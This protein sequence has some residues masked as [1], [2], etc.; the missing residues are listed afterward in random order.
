[1]DKPVVGVVTKAQIVDH[2]AQILTKVMGN[3]KDVQMCIYHVSW[4]TNNRLCVPGVL[5]VQPDNNF[6]FE[7][8]DYE[9]LP[10]RKF[11]TFLPFENFLIVYR[12]DELT[13]EELKRKNPRGVLISPGPGEPQDSGI[14]LQT[15]LELGPTVP[16]FGVCMG[17]QCMGE[18]FGGKIVRSPYGVMHGK[19]SLVY[20]DEKGEDGLLAG[21]P[22]VQ[23]R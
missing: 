17:L 16:V 22:K 9:G 21:L 3:E 12:N 2:H 6:E 11:H 20:Y 15:V 10:F 19:S 4:K 18:A 7:N 5:S 13:V 23:F 8:K 14:S 1:M